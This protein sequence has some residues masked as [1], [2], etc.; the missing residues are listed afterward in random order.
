MYIIRDF[1]EFT[2]KDCPVFPSRIC[3]WKPWTSSNAT[4]LLL[5][6]LSRN[7]C[8]RS[9]AIVKQVSMSTHKIALS[10]QEGTW[11]SRKNQA[12]NR[13]SFT[14]GWGKMDPRQM[15]FTDVSSGPVKRSSTIIYRMLEILRQE[16][17]EMQF[18][19]DST[20]LSIFSLSRLNKKN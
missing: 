12:W 17:S 4:L 8:V 10:S 16:G 18:T 13:L 5:L 6:L 3:T 7:C 9:K 14:T 11:I 15:D 2:K 20:K 19:R 1:V